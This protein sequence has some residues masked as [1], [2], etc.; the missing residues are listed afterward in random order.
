MY[1]ICIV[2]SGETRR[3]PEVKTMG[4]ERGAPGQEEIVC[5]HFVM[6]TKYFPTGYEEKTVES[7]RLKGRDEK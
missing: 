5:W 6:Q 3:F 7:N 1:T 2:N 4:A